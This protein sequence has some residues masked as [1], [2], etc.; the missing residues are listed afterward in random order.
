MIITL[1]G[2]ARFERE[3]HL[4]N[5]ALTMAGHTVFSLAVFPSTRG[6]EKSW[7]SDHEKE[8]LDLAHL[9]KISASHAILVINKEGYIGDSCKREILWA[10]TQSKAIYSTFPMKL[11]GTSAQMHPLSELNCKL[12]R[13]EPTLWDASLT[14]TEDPADVF[15]DEKRFM[16]MMEQTT[17]EF[18][19]EQLRLYLGLILEEVSETLQAACPPSA[20]MIKATLLQLSNALKRTPA[21]FADPATIDIIEVFDGLLDILVVTINAGLSAGLPMRGGWEAVLR[22]NM[23]K[24][25]PDGRL[26]RRADGKI[27][28]PEGWKPPTE[29][30]V[31]LLQSNRTDLNPDID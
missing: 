27:L 9:A 28:K 30:L 25:G 6:G 22:S 11:M 26:I 2:S 23:A 5:E 15:T 13:H 20:S 3:F 29:D 16:T 24:V 21:S 10:V 18:N 8:L 14:T 19:L 31:A 7:Y 1:C 12:P 17:D 4:W